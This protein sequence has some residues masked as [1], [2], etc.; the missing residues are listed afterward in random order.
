MKPFLP[1]L[2]TL[3]LLLSSCG[4]QKS[5]PTT[6]TTT[7]PPKKEIPAPPPAQPC[8]VGTDGPIVVIDSGGV[9]IRSAPIVANDNVLETPKQ[10][11]GFGYIS[12][13]V[14][15]GVRWHKICFQNKVAWVSGEH[16][17][18]VLDSD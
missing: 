9:V 1:L 10:Y 4:D 14:V 11:A 8:N 2:L 17:G 18:V 3:F 16:T 13:S 6:D 12:D 15:N 7:T 5:P